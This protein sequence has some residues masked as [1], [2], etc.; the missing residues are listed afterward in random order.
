[1]IIEAT[2]QSGPATRIEKGK[3]T[4][5]LVYSKK[6][7]TNIIKANLSCL[8]I[9]QESTVTEVQLKLMIASNLFLNP[10]L[11]RTMRG[12]SPRIVEEGSRAG[13]IC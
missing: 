6:K 7:R 12:M 11:T 4:H 10:V 2:L 13:T 9:P 1:M 5:I 8:G 3:L